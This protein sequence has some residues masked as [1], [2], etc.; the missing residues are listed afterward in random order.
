MAASKAF[1]VISFT[2]LVAMMLL[3]SHVASANPDESIMPMVKMGRKVLGVVVDAYGTPKNE[4]P[5]PRYADP[6]FG[7]GPILPP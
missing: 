4:P 7:G 2:L 5:I 3:S 6:G 1:S